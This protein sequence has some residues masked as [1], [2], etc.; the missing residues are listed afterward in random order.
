[1]FVRSEITAAVSVWKK[2]RTTHIWRLIRQHWG[3]SHH[4]FRRRV[5]LNKSSPGCANGQKW[6]K[7]SIIYCMWAWV[8][9]LTQED[10]DRAAPCRL[11]TIRFCLPA[12]TLK[13]FEVKNTS[14][15]QVHPIQVKFSLY[16]FLLHDLRKHRMLQKIT[17]H[18]KLVILCK[19]IPW[20]ATDR[21]SEQENNIWDG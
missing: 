2:T 7:V 18:E 8:N 11:T 4:F 13:K 19:V 14:G 15:L 6:E 9:H 16:L 12:K 3:L 10:F 17:F 20:T 5:A 1:M 21:L